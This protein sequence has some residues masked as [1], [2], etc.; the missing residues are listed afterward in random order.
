M[1][2]RQIEIVRQ[3]F[4]RIAPI[5]AVAAELFYAHLF[6]MN[7]SLR[8][9]FK[10]DM[11]RQGA[12]LMSMIGSAVRGLDNP[13]ALVPVLKSLGRRHEGYGVTDRHYEDVR[14]ALMWTLA[15]GLGDAFD[16]EA[17]DAWM[18]A[19]ELLSSVMRL[20]ARELHVPQAAAA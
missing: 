11:P 9:L 18:Q 4:E 14:E 17:R 19:Y 10:G 3:G 5:A 12:M 8:S 6:E 1:T 20:G 13:Q 16:A 15:H 2:P 7:P